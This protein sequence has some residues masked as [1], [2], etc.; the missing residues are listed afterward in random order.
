M[1]CLQAMRSTKRSL[2]EVLDRQCGSGLTEDYA[3]DESDASL[4][5]FPLFVAS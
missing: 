1:F 2:T 5:K 4:W 3:L